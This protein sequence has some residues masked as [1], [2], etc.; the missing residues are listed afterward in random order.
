MI[1]TFQTWESVAEWFL[2]DA[3]P[4]LTLTR[5]ALGHLHVF[6]EFFQGNI[7]PN[8]DIS[9]LCGSL[10]CLLQVSFPY[11]MPKLLVVIILIPHTAY[12][13]ESK[14]LRS[15]PSDDQVFSS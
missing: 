7:V 13:Q 12:I 5:P 2:R 3:P 9:Y 4:P 8:I 10:V 6:V 14:G 11:A 1:E 15:G